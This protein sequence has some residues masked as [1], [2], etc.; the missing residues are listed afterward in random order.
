MKIFEALGENGLQCMHRALEVAG[1]SAEY[2]RWLRY[3]G[4]LR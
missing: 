1:A 3:R 2:A 4:W